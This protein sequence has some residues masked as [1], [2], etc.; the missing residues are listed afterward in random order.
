MYVEK[1]KKIFEN[2]KYLAPYAYHVNDGKKTTA[3]VRDKYC[4]PN[5]D[6]VKFAINVFASNI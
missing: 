3:L 1:I 6:Q 2:V 5:F 4:P